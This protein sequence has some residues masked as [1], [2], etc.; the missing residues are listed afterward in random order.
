MYVLCGRWQLHVCCG[1]NRRG[2]AVVKTPRRRHD[3]QHTSQQK[4]ENIIVTDGKMISHLLRDQQLIV[5]NQ[6]AVRVTDCFPS[7]YIAFQLTCLDSA[8]IFSLF[9]QQFVWPFLRFVDCIVSRLYMYSEYTCTV[10]LWVFIEIFRWVVY[11]LSKS[12]KWTHVAQINLNGKK[13]YY[14]RVQWNRSISVFRKTSFYL[15]G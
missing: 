5:H 15:S 13:S 14:V 7:H 11:K 10:H 1:D 2:K 8:F 12:A 6:L 9:D 4:A 3:G